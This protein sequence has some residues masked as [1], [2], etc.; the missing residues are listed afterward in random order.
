MAARSC[1]SALAHAAERTGMQMR[2]PFAFVSADDE[3]LV[4][5]IPVQ[6]SRCGA[7]DLN[8]LQHSFA[9]HVME[10]AGRIKLEQRQLLVLVQQR[11]QRELKVLDVCWR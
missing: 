6:R 11:L 3:S 7:T 2:S 1:G 4:S 9:R 8:P 10:G 5:Q